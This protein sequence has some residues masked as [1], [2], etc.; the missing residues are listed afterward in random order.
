M[1]LFYHYA[2]TGF[3]KQY[4]TGSGIKHLTGEK[5]ETVLVPEVC[6]NDQVYTVRYIEEKIS[7]CNNI[8]QTVDTALQQAAALRQSIL[9]QAFEGNL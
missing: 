9:K 2:Q 7:V 4:F 6:R 1:Y 5:L 3:L 8:E